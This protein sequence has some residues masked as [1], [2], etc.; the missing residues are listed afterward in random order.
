MKRTILGLQLLILAKVSTEHSFTQYFWA[1]L[2]ILWILFN[3]S[4]LYKKA[5]HEQNL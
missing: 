4:Q 1:A 5:K 3:F 2:C